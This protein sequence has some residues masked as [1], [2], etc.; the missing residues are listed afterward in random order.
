MQ[1]TI[2]GK[3]VTVLKENRML[4]H[5]IIATNTN[6]VYLSACLSLPVTGHFRFKSDFL[7]FLASLFFLNYFPFNLILFLQKKVGGLKPQPLPL[8]LAC[9]RGGLAG[10]ARYTSA[11]AKREARNIRL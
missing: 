7:L 2:S 8:C 9:R 3:N 11:R 1:G 5:N 4:S 10:P 6:S